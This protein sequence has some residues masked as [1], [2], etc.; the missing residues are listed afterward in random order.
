MFNSQM[1]DTAIGLIF[2]YF[3]LSLLCSVIIETVTGLTKKRPR[4][5]SEGIL[6]L[7]QD[8]KALSKLYEQPLFM[9]KST[10]K[11]LFKS[12]GENFIPLRFKKAIFPSY[13][14]SRSFVLSLLESLKQ[15]PDVV[16]KLLR[17]KISPPDNK[18]QIK[19]FEN[20]LNSLPYDSNIKKALLPLLQS[21]GSETEKAFKSVNEW[22]DKTMTKPPEEILKE[23]KLPTIGKYLQD[24][25]NIVDCLPDDNAIKKALLPLLDSA[26]GSVDKAIENI[27]KWYDE[28][29]ERVTG[30]YKRYSQ[31]F[32][33]IL[34][35]VVALVLN[36][37]TFQIG[38]AIYRD[39]ALRASLVKMAE[40]AGEGPRSATKQDSQKEQP[41]TSSAS[42]QEEPGKRKQ[43]VKMASSPTTSP[44]SKTE[45]GSTPA[46]AIQSTESGQ[47]VPGS[48]P[49]S[50]D[51]EK[52]D[53]GKKVK[54]IDDM[55][56]QISS[57][58]LPIGW[59]FK[60]TEA[61]W[62]AKLGFKEQPDTE[63]LD[64]VKV[65]GIFL[66]A[67][68]ASLGS[69]FWFELLNKFLNL[70]NAGKKPLTKE[71]Q[72]AQKK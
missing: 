4:M 31:A 63:G 41:G 37:D 32:A 67:L 17:D 34:A 53:W 1:L 69:N 36:A 66:T 61:P 23:I 35:F 30:W 47:A 6:S 25:R 16:K 11:N 52:V 55:Y 8:S 27:E 57:L 33:L 15:H 72:E 49:P 28:A 24:A 44:K 42:G 20:K 9:G 10:P 22:Y 43:G 60:E 64:L 18:D 38:K 50:S 70:R 62:L 71:E 54:E 19:E 45:V 65:L 58:N 29:M 3:L 21:A 51:P 68:M 56:K 2:V 48:R 13:I 7:L 59:P 14:S 46:A 12:I 5:L 40:K 39:Q 26:D